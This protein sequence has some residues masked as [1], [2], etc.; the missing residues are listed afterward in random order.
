MAVGVTPEHLSAF[1]NRKE[2]HSEELIAKLHRVT[3]ISAYLLVA[4][5]TKRLSKE[6]TEFFKNQRMRKIISM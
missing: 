6:F 2:G 5:S 4:G 1:K 3:G